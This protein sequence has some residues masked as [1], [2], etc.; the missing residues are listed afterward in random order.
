MTVLRKKQSDQ[1]RWKDKF[2]RPVPH[3]Q[4][5][6]LSLVGVRP[7]EEEPPDIPADQS[8]EG[9]SLGLTVSP[10]QGLAPNPKSLGPTVG[11]SAPKKI[12]WD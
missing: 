5:R 2:D 12:S 11:P 10:E 4:E 9:Q 6:L 1:E 3:R 7:T 8:A